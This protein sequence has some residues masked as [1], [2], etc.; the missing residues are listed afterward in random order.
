MTIKQFNIIQIKK[1]LIILI[2][3]NLLLFGI[4]FMIPLLSG[5]FFFI[6]LVCFFAGAIG[7]ALS[8]QQRVH[9]IS[10][11]ELNILANSWATL[12]F[13]P[14]FSGVFALILYVV[15]LANI[16][17]GNLFPKFEIPHETTKGI[18]S[19]YF[20]NLFS[21]TY[22]ASLQDIARLIFWCFIAGFSERFVPNIIGKASKTGEEENSTE[23]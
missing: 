6:S 7:G 9:K 21:N 1:K 16:V 11:G 20:I 13:V 15:F 4:T 8:L 19:R 18:D 17:D 23:K 3:I 5:R 22:P 10:G 14:I 12:L 2:L